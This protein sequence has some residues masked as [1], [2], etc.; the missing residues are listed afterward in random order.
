MIGLWL[1]SGG[2]VALALALLLP[3]L[4]R[5]RSAGPTRLDCDL[6]VFRDQ[7]REIERE[8]ERG[9]IAPGEAE[10]ARLEIQRRML[11]AAQAESKPGAAAKH[12]GAG[13]RW[14][15]AAV[16]FLVPAGAFS[17]YLALG[18]PG[19]TGRAFAE[20]QASAA[21]Q[22][23]GEA[24]AHAN[25]EQ[26]VDR[27][28]E[29]LKGRPDDLDGWLMLARSYTSLERFG[30]AARAYR[31]AVSASQNRSDV[32]AD[33]AESLVLASGGSVT[34]EARSVL[35]GVFAADALNPKARYYLGLSSAQRGDLGAALQA[36]VDLL[37]LAPVDAPWLPFVDSQVAQAARQAGLD[38]ASLK[39]SPEAERLARSVAATGVRAGAP[40]P[41]EARPAI[42]GPSAEDM[43]AAQKMSE[44]DRA[45]MIRGMVD[46][47]AKR[48]EENPN[49]RDG[50]L[51]LARAYEVLGEREKAK[52]A[53]ARAEALKP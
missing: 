44:S 5:R 20:R 35:E 4:V 6:A 32:A 30:D 14:V 29:R 47:L 36:W 8:E 19:T 9:V 39:P 28:A 10:A 38:R 48:L 27:L 33:Y 52:G 41:G 23:A 50:W 13:G 17:L 25:L 26:A 42:P 3:P 16:A 37:R 1:A 40:P 51:R 53:Q 43:D 2:L 24:A 46:R 22:D 7:L 18:S 45:A 15:A 21:G 31:Q 11:A 34:A 12:S 49:D